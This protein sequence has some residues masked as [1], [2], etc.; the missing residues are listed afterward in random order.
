MFFFKFDKTMEEVKQ[1]IDHNEN[2]MII[3]V[4]EEDEY[5]AGHLPKAHLFPLTT[6]DEELH[7]LPKDLDLYVYCRSGQRARTAVRKLRE[8]GYERVYNIGGI[9]HWPYE[10]ESR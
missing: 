8:A 5:D 2:V 1:V 3:D 7:Q 10:I 4:R 6:F 9:I